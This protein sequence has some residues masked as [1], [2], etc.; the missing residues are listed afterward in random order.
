VGEAKTRPSASNVNEYLASRSSAEQLADCRAL[1][2]L[3]R[4]V[5]GEKPTMWG[6]SIVGFGSYRYPLAG[7]KLGESCATG[8]AVRGK[9]IVV[10]LVAEGKDQSALLAKLGK[11]KFGKACLYF[12]RLS[13]LDR[14]VLEQLVVGSLAE[15]RR[16]WPQQSVQ[17]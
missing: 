3:L 12:R 17:R 11:H 15:I 13:D 6:P 10:Y 16:R 8:F 9:E 1:I 7:G 4:R 5:T 14:K 2:A